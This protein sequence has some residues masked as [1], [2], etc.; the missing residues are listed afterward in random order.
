MAGGGSAPT[1][2]KCSCGHGTGTTAISRAPSPSTPM[3][4]AP[5]AP[6]RPP[7]VQCP[8]ARRP[9]AK[10]QPPSSTT[11]RGHGRCP[12]IFLPSIVSSS[13]AI[14]LSQELRHVLKPRDQNRRHVDAGHEYEREMR[15]HG[16]VGGLGL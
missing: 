8:A 6:P 10:R 14:G 13:A 5:G 2:G 4:P 16:H 7:S 9:S 11:S 3:C 15:K 1:D 12:A